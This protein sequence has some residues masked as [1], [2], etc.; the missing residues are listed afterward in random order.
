[1]ALAGGLGAE[2]DLAG[3]PTVAANE[4][5]RVAGLPDAVVLFSESNTRFL[6]EVRPDAAGEFEAYF[7]GL[8]FGRVGTV[9]DQGRLEIGR[10]PRPLAERGDGRSAAPPVISTDLAS[11]KEAWQIPL[12]W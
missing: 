10:S 11:L 7:V 3:V 9:V 4:R 1:M 2:I 8:P 12:R 5:G 6:C